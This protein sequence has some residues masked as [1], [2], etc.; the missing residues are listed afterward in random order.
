[1][2][3]QADW[4]RMTM[5]IEHAEQPLSHEDTPAVDKSVNKSLIGGMVAGI[6]ASVCCVGP[7]LLLSLGVS[8]TWIGNLSAMNA[9]RPW[10]IG[11]TLVFLFLAFRKLY[12]KP[13]S[14]AVDAPCASEN[15]LR[16]QRILFWVVSVFLLL[17]ITFQ[18]YGLY[19]LN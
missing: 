8:G 10:F 6:T 15:S 16:K 11:L 9:Y 13:P 4:K 7:L 2:N 18:Y 17:L 14:C 19:L 1:M 12:L 5:N 3:R